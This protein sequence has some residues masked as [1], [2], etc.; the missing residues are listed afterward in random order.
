MKRQIFAALAAVVIAAG[1]VWA[2]NT[3]NYQAQGGA[4]WVVGGTL[5]VV[6]GGD[7][8]IETGGEID[9]ES[10]GGIDF[11]SGSD[12]DVLSGAALDIQSGAD[13]DI[14]SGADL[15]I[16]SGGD[17]EVEAGGD[18]DVTGDINILVGGDLDV[19]SGGDLTID[20]G[21]ALTSS[22]G[23]T[24]NLA[25]TIK[26]AGTTM[27]ASAGELNVWDS[28]YGAVTAV[29]DG[30]ETS[31]AHQLTMT[32]RDAD[33]GTL[34]RAG[35]GTIV[36]SSDAQTPTPVAP[37]AATASTGQLINTATGVYLSCWNASGANV[38]DWYEDEADVD[39]YVLFI[40]PTGAFT[41]SVEMDFAP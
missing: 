41:A 21:A 36:Y 7:L 32:A 6:S 2:Y 15:D 29:T 14:E 8:D 27:T 22:S 23:S 1:A 24:V 38:V 19:E 20:S 16:Q 40:L 4:Q 3:S 11:E 30:T 26:I 34:S 39:R 25:G 12:L 9:I 28:A 5:D 33:G 13:L 18:I 37:S 10:G 31:N 35:C 17:L